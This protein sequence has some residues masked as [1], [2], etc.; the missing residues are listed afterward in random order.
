MYHETTPD[1]LRALFKLPAA[2]TVDAAILLGRWR[3]EEAMAQWSARLT[4]VRTPGEAWHNALFGAHQGT[5]LAFA[6][7]Y[8][9][10]M[11]AECLRAFQILGARRVVQLGYFGGL[12]PHMTRGDVIVPKIA[13]RMDG[14]SDAFLPRELNVSSDIR[15]S[16]SL[17]R[18]ILAREP[19][20]VI[21]RSPQVTISGGILSETRTQIKA[22]SNVGYGGVDLETATTFALASRFGMQAAAALVCSDVVVAEDSLFERKEGPL[23]ERMHAMR[24]HIDEAALEVVCA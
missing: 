16:Q 11:T 13:V 17:K 20:S 5:K 14:A 12:Q 22:W 9:P 7:T 6:V 21:H 1:T 3:P 10:T 2:Y 18:A 23:R 15:L 4:D 19:E 8:G 24:G